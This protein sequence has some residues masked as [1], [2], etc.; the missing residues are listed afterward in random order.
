MSPFL[1]AILLHGLCVASAIDDFTTVYEWE[2]F[3]YLWP[4]GADSSIAEIK[5]NFNPLEADLRYMAVFGERLFLSIIVHSGTPASLVWLPKSGTSTA[6]APP[7]LAPFPSWD[8]HKK[9]NCNTIQNARGLEPDTEG[10][11]WVVDDGNS[12]CQ[13]KLWIF[14]LLNNDATDRIH[15]FPNTFVHHEYGL[16]KL[17]DIAVDKTPD[18][19]L[20]YITDSYCE[21]IIVYSRKMDK[22]WTV[23]TPGTRWYS[24]ALSPIREARQLYLGSASANELYS[25]SVSEL[26]NEGGNATVKLIGKWREELYRMVIDTSN[27]LYAAMLK[28]N[29][30]S[31]WNISEPFRKRRFHEVEG[32]NKYLPFTLALDTTNTLWVTER[33]QSGGGNRYKLLKASVDTST[34]TGSTTPQVNVNE[35]TSEVVKSAQTPTSGAYAGLVG[36]HP[37]SQSS[38]TIIPIL[39]LVSFLVL[40]GTVILW[41]TLRMRRMRTTFRQI[42]MENNGELYVFPERN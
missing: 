29:Y 26:K 6:T 39:L 19:S 12:N 5:Q 30:L 13:A 36:D 32:L 15:Q 18:D 42:Q 4:S 9:D 23:N 21:H 34:S 1:A 16:R 41:L 37:K 25:I 3:D 14:D 2:K 27:V 10:R 35:E 20:A 24:L 40:S 8:L 38:N 7:K 22:S 33:N 31:K 28:Q 17:V 11:L